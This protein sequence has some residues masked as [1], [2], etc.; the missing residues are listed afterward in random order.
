M[1]KAL[2]IES[3]QRRKDP[4]R[5]VLLAASLDG[6]P[7]RLLNLSFGGVEIA[8]EQSSSS[9]A[10]PVIGSEHLLEF[11]G[12]A[13]RTAK[14]LVKV[15]WVETGDGLFGACFEDLDDQQYGKLDLLIMA[16]ALSK[17]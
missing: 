14:F 4:R 10:P 8:L 16:R 12:V 17:V 1:A 7:V 6:M 9:D 3:E 13:P 5:D 11:D 2:N 15:I